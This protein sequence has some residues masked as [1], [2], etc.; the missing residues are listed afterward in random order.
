MSEG[1]WVVPLAALASLDRN[2]RSRA[3]EPL[4]L[5]MLP[6]PAA[7]KTAVAAVAVTQQ[8]RDGI[9]REKQV[10][11]QT[12]EAVAE[13]QANP[14]AF[15]KDNLTQRR[16]LRAI[17]T[18]DLVAQIQAIPAT[19][20]ANAV[21]AAAKAVAVDALSAVKAAIALQPGN[22]IPSAD[23]AKY[24]ELVANLTDAQKK[25]IFG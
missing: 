20:D 24:P 17:A 1:Q 16:A 13:A 23:E 3:T 6:G 18:D 22:K 8:A 11:T 5:T 12:V 14:A 7:T 21:K 2:S 4:M 25:D 19:V 10:A 9:R 15:T